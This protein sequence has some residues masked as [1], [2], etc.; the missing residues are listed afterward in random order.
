[1]YGV[2]V[3]TFYNTLHYFIFLKIKYNVTTDSYFVSCVVVIFKGKKEMYMNM[4]I[5]DIKNMSHSVD[6]EKIINKKVHWH[7]YYKKSIWV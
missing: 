2:T 7:I 1:M 4:E 5:I 6:L 3:N